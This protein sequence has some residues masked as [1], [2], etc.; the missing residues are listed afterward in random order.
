MQKAR[1][2]FLK[3]YME[4]ICPTGYEEEASRVWREEA[5]KFA[6]RTWIDQHG[7]SFAVV[8]EKGA[9]RIMLAGHADEIGLLVTH[10]DEAGYLS[11]AGLGGWDVQVLPGQ[12]VRIKTKAG[13]VLGVIGRKPIHLLDAEERKKVVKMEDLWIDIG[14]KDAKEAAKL[15]DIG[16]PAVLDYEF[17]DLRNGLVT[18]RGFDDRIGAFVVLE[19]ARLAAKMKPKAAIYAVA[20]VQEEIGLR[21]ATTSAYGIDP[22]VGIAVDVGHATDTP[23]MTKE[24][25]RIGDAKMGGGPIV[26]RGPNVNT[27]LFDRI[28][29][30]AKAKEIP[31]Q[32]HAF[33]R[34]TGTDARAI[35]ITRAGVATAVVGVPNRYMH[36]PSEVVQLGDVE[37]CAK[38]IAE[39]IAGIGPK[40]SFLPS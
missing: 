36:S 22:Q 35:Q 39:T 25:K 11:F 28:V 15:V 1:L 20:T 23:R 4:T 26:T 21:G 14:A 18:A 12:R 9:P 7:N 30:T 34:P 2:D 19:A 3:R 37:N 13:I 10:I 8:N 33:P 38:L 6:D 27:P 17:A 40:T 16:D 32:I 5:D 29:K 24:K 31:I